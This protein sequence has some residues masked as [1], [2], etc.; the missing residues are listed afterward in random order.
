[1]KEYGTAI[2]VSGDKVTVSVKRTA[3][4]DRCGRCTHPHIVFGDDSAFI[5]EAVAAGEISPGDSVEL[6][7]DSGD[8]LT[9]SFLIWTLP[10][11]AGAAGLILGWALGR[12]VGDSGLWATVFSLASLG[13]SFF[14]L[15]HYDKSSRRS[16][17]F[18][19]LA[20][21]VKDLE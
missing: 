9:A 6:T 13:L 5:I 8:F 4:C 19:P 15:Y 2:G 14:W 7:M 17:R 1:M 21:A 18:L 20:R 11:M 12:V 10:L 16:G 3:A